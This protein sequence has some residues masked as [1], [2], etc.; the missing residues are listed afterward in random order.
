MRQI[1]PAPE[2]QG[3]HYGLIQDS[4]ENKAIYN[5]LKIMVNKSIQVMVCQL[6]KDR[7]EVRGNR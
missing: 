6:Q 7:L 3:G 5:S 4:Q 2:K 1:L